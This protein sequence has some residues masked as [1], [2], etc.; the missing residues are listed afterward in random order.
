VS[1]VDSAPERITPLWTEN[2]R[3]EIKSQN[4]NSK[5]TNQNSNSKMDESISRRGWLFVPTPQIKAKSHE[6]WQTKQSEC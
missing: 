5:I 1:R 6:D 2:N 3:R 4:V